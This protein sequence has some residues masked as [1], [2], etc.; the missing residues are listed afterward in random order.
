MKTQGLTHTL[1]RARV[2]IPL[3]LVAIALVQ[4]GAAAA[5]PETARFRLT[6]TGSLFSD[7]KKDV[8]GPCG[9]EKGTATELIHFRQSRPVTIQFERGFAGPFLQATVPGT[10]S[11]GIPITGDIS[12]SNHFTDSPNGHCMGSY[13]PTATYTPPPKPDCGTKRFHAWAVPSW[14]KPEHY[15]LEVSPAPTQPVFWL[16]ELRLLPD[17]FVNCDS[18]APLVLMQLNTATFTPK[19]AF[20]R[21]ARFTLHADRDMVV[22]PDHLGTGSTADTTVRWTVHLN[23]IR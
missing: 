9:N 21:G 15:P 4:A 18:W 22:G 17:P 2:A 13:D 16:Y 23:R 20:G 5:R 1:R 6:V 10:R 8:T 19:Q 11:Q 3:L 12:R 7:F 14:T